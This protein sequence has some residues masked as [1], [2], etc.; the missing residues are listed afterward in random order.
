MYKGEKNIRIITVFHILAQ[1]L[2]TTA[3]G[4]QVHPENLSSASQLI[5]FIN[6]KV[7]DLFSRPNPDGRI[8]RKPDG[9]KSDKTAE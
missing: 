2:P 5:K 7:A 1:W 6:K 8:N 4:P 9:Q 3:P